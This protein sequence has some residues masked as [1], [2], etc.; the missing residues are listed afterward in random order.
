MKYL[1]HARRIACVLILLMGA[2]SAER[3]PADEAS[4]TAATAE[5]AHATL[6][7]QNFTNAIEPIVI[8]SSEFAAPA[9]SAESIPA[10]AASVK[11]SAA[12]EA[13]ITAAVQTPTGPKKPIVV[14]L[15]ESASPDATHASRAP[16][17]I[18]PASSQWPTP[19]RFFTINQVLAKHQQATSTS[20]AMHLAAIDPKIVSDAS[21]GPTRLTRDDE[22]FGLFTFRAPDGLLWA[23]WRGVEADIQAEAP[24]LARCRA[25]PSHCTPAAARFVAIIKQAEARQGRA[26]FEF[27]NERINTAIHYMTD[28]AQWG[29]ADLWSAPLDTNNKGSFDTGFG[30]C[31]DYAIAKYVALRE[32][33]VSANDLRLL[34]VRDNSVRLDHAVLVARQDRSWLILDNRWTRLIDDTEAK[35]FMPLFSIDEKGVKLFAAPY[36]TKRPASSKTVDIEDQRF[37]AGADASEFAQAPLISRGTGIGAAP[38]IL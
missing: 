24:A 2:F 22:P 33:G 14:A 20:S 28:M 19:A 26:K 17:A 38:L 37:G 11:P 18:P 3:I 6:T 32:A 35:Q 7:Y 8:A 16:I 36:A 10:P 9:L 1:A 30:D 23:K 27:V 13:T 25:E 29:V 31:E 5:E 4:A 15:A 21:P 34:L 12:D